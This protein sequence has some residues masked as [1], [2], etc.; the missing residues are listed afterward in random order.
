MN[1]IRFDARDLASTRAVR[2]GVAVAILVLASTV[3]CI[4]RTVT[5]NTEPQGAT[6]FLNDE[7][8]GQSPVRVPFTWYGDYDIILRKEGFKTVQAHHRLHTPW[9]QYPFIDI[10]S[11]C[12]I[13]FTIHDDHVIDTFALETYV[14]PDKDE[15]LHRSGELRAR[16]LS[17]TGG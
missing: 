2:R 12:F 3:G 17:E 7:E 4:E 9:Y 14:A 13:P 6:V 8:V 15:L 5:I 16:A 10:V 1:G 11:E